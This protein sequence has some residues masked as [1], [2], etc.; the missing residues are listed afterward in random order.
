MTIYGR[1][2]IAI[3]KGV[4]QDTIHIIRYADDFVILHKDKEVILECRK[5]IENYLA[6][7]G[8]ELSQAKTRLTHTLRLKE[9]DTKEQGFDGI[10]GF[11]FLGFTIKQFKTRHRSAKSTTGDLL[12]YKTLIY[13]S[14]K[15]M[16]EHQTQLHDI[17][18]HQGK[19][20]DQQTLIKKVNPVIRGWSNYF[21]RSHAGTT[22]DLNIADYLTYLKLRRWSKRI[23]GTSSTGAKCWKRIGSRKWVFSHGD[24]ILINHLD[25]SNSISD[26]VKVKGIASPFD[27][28]LSVYWSKRM[29]SY[30]GFNKRTQVLLSKQKGCCKL[31]GTQFQFDDVMEIDHIKPKSL[32]GKDTYTNLQLLHGYCHDQKTA[33][34]RKTNKNV[35]DDK[36]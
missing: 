1:T 14:K 13:P 29:K 35:K 28:T 5:E 23:Q 32:G 16:K 9:E 22:G 34:E 33:L 12:G 8:L 11:N 27:I 10:I 18:L 3:A 17:I 25:Y 6:E 21:G 36:E 4:I 31:C 7:I 15:S 20:W 24:T 30:P 2:G 19:T 26:Y